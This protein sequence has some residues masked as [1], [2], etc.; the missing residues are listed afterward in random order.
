VVVPDGVQAGEEFQVSVPL[1]E[2]EGLEHWGEEQEQDQEQLEE[3]EQLQEEQQEQEQEQLEQEQ[4]EEQQEEQEQEQGHEH[5]QQQEH[6]Q[7]QEQEQEEGEAADSVTELAA[8]EPTPMPSRRRYSVSL[9]SGD[10]D[11][12]V[13]E[14][15]IDVEETEEG[16]LLLNVACP[17]GCAAGDALFVMTPDG[18]E[19]EVVVPDGVQAGEEFQVSVP[20]PEEEGLEGEMEDADVEL[21]SVEDTVLPEMSALPRLQQAVRFRLSLQDSHSST[22]AVCT[23]GVSYREG[24]VKYLNLRPTP[25]ADYSLGPLY[26]TSR[27][28]KYAGSRC[29]CRELTT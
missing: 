17:E 16:D 5:E 3:Q 10:L 15:E 11:S 19:V 9:N 22:T 2:E 23:Y 14:I 25:A 29:L 4:L 28:G 26:R 20:P 13:Q 8:F 21:A 12:M 6:E 27:S 1:P 18:R 7:E 24:C